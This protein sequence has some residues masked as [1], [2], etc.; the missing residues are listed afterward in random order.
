[1][2]MAL[3]PFFYIC[4][5]PPLQG[6]GMCG[7]MTNCPKLVISSTRS[8]GVFQPTDV[9]FY[10]IN[11]PLTW[12]W[13]T[14]YGEETS[15]AFKFNK[16]NLLILFLFDLLILMSSQVF[17]LTWLTDWHQ[18]HS[19]MHTNTHSLS[20]KT[21]IK[22]VSFFAIVIKPW[23]RQRRRRYSIFWKEWQFSREICEITF[24]A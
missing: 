24:I 4:I 14:E 20:G 1:M 11:L 6:N 19:F 3:L 23:R 12:K 18:Y 7:C 2:M 8:L 10:L 21:T 5:L 17:F 9:S 22:F 15:L 13:A 16:T